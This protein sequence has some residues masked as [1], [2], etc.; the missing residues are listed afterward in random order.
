MNKKALFLLMLITFSYT[1]FAQPPLKWVKRFDFLTFEDFGESMTIDNNKNIYFAGFSDNGGYQGTEGLFISKMD[2]T[3]NFLWHYHPKDI[4]MSYAHAYKIRTDTLGNIYLVFGLNGTISFGVD[5]I[6]SFYGLH[7]VKLVDSVMVWHIELP[8]GNTYESEYLLETNVNGTCYFM[9]NFSGTKILGPDTITSS[10]S[11]DIFITK[12][13]SNGQFVW[14]RAYGNPSTSR[15]DVSKGLSLDSLENI[16]G[17]YSQSYLT[18]SGDGK[19]NIVK[20]DSAGFLLNNAQITG[21][22]WNLS[23]T[24]IDCFTTSASGKSYIVLEI[25]GQSTIIKDTVI[26]LNYEGH[27]LVVYDSSFNFYSAAIIIDTLQSAWLLIPSVIEVN[28]DDNIYIGG[29]SWLSFNFGQDSILPSFFVLNFDSTMIFKWIKDFNTT[30]S[31]NTYAQLKDIAVKDDSLFFLCND[32]GNLLYFDNYYFHSS[33]Y[34]VFAGCMKI[35]EDSTL[36]T[37]TEDWMFNPTLNIFPN[38]VHDLVTIDFRDIDSDNSII[39]LILY[40]ITGEVLIK[41]RLNVK[42]DLSL[43]LSALSQGVYVLSLT[44]NKGNSRFKLVKN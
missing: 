14:T 44:H 10:G 29:R 16:Y 35:S 26:N 20:L 13:S 3:R 11:T 8:T 43:D 34:D 18:S 17:Y 27:A 23:E 31:S 7:L 33:E 4:S 22:P 40:N 5:T 30:I 12:I 6:T 25:N 32:Y 2:S 28:Y 15:G 24:K 42:D 38:P 41:K 21:F 19:S 9:S 36:I 39:E 1:L 37:L